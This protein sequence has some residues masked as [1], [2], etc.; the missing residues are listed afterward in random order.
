[1]L[2]KDKPYAQPRSISVYPKIPRAQVL[3][4]AVVLRCTQELQSHDR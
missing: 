1:M 3:R 2:V 4:Q